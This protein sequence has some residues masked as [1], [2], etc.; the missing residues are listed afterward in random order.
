MKYESRKKKKQ[1][2]FYILG[3]LL[4]LIIKIW[5]FG[6][7]FVFEIWRIWAIFFKGKSFV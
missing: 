5:R 3:Y 1:E 7:K 4:E 6:K 2:S